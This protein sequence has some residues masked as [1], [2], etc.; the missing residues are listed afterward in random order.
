M[1]I[2][3]NVINKKISY[4]RRS[5]IF[6]KSF[7]LIKKFLRDV[8]KPNLPLIFIFIYFLISF[9]FYS[10][11]NSILVSYLKVLICVTFFLISLI[12]FSFFSNKFSFT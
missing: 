10:F 4:L 6:K 1:K 7:S 5:Q 8:L 11:V 9:N 2:E 12:L 3:N